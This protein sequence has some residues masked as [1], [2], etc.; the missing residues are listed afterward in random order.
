MVDAPGPARVTY[1][2]ARLE[3]AIRVL[4][5]DIVRR[6]DLTTPQY[7]AMSVLARGIK[8][9]SAQLA[10]RVFVTPQ[11]MN[12]IIVELEARGLIVRTPSAANKRVL[13]A[14]LSP[15][16]RRVLDACD[17]EVDDV[18]KRML[19]S[20]TAA[21]VESLRLSLSACA[22]ELARRYA[23]HAGEPEVPA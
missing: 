3:R 10:R 17:E 15:S 16:G 8:L 13:F 18:E 12:L 1:L 19:S 7:T 20:S 14:E 2:V 22:E 23:E 11:A 9:S 21:E 4:I 5:D 6:H